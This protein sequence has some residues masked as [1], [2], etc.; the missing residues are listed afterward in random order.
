MAGLGRMGGSAGLSRYRSAIR[1]SSSTS[2]LF[3]LTASE[4]SAIRKNPSSLSSPS[5]TYSLF[6]TMTY[7]PVTVTPQCSSTYF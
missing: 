7:V 2:L 6:M 4:T 3:S 5:N 1:R